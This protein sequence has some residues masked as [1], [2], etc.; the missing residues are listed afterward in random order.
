VA[1]LALSLNPWHDTPASAT[2]FLKTRQV[3]I[4][5]H[6]L[7]GTEKTLAPIW[8]AYHMQSILQANGIVIHSTGLYLIDSAGRERTFFEEGFDPKVASQQIHQLI[9]SPGVVAQPTGI[10]GVSR[11]DFTASTSDQGYQIEFTATPGQFGTYDYTVTALDP[12]GVPLQNAHVTLDLTM[13]AMVM[14]PLLVTMSPTNPPIPG[15]YQAHAVLSMVGVWQA[16][17]SVTPNGSSQAVTAKF[18]FTSQT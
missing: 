4:P 1:W 17:V 18:T 6:Y 10:T 9:T 12:D 14:S 11:S 15:S 2:A 3:S 5:M 7:L 8:S 16:T 13:Q